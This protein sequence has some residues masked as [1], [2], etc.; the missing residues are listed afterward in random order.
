M[1]KLVTKFKYYKPG[2]SVSMGGYLKYIATREGVEKYVNSKQFAPPTVKQK[3]L[4]EKML[5]EYPDSRTM[6]EYEDYLAK[7]SRK[8]AT[9]FLARAIEDNIASL[10]NSKTYAD[11]IA[12]RPGTERFGTH[13]LFTDDE[14]E[15][16]LSKV[17]GELNAHAGN[18]WTMIVS[19]RR[20]DAVRLG[21]DNASAWRD[22]VRANTKELADAFKIPLTKLRW[23]AAFHN[24]AHH[25]HIHVMVYS[26]TK[27]IGY[28]TKQGVS[29]MRAALAKSIFADDLQNV[30]AEQ[31]VVRN[32][33]KSNVKEILV[34]IMRIANLDNFANGEIEKKLLYLAERLR[35]TKGKKVY[36]YLKPDVKEIIDSIVDI[37][38]K[39]DTINALYDLWYEKKFSALGM[40]ASQMPPR[41]PLADNKEF[42]SIKNDIIREALLLNGE[43]IENEN[44]NVN[45]KV[46]VSVT[47]LFKN[48]CSVFSNKLDD[49]N[50][51][52]KIYVSS[53]RRLRR[54]E[55][56]KKNA[57]LIYD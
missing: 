44:R 46:A 25:P 32:E 8:T 23:Y 31:T 37:L 45:A 1:S 22:I 5:V 12:T 42:K 14:K 51:K 3:E 7:P 40:Y 55:E 17:S 54:E 28:L 9:E 30:Y 29:N 48:L 2:A 57:E 4:I 10:M 24:S 52:G 47:R 41:I 16:V 20:E 36:G 34:E 56:A 26:D 38:A 49:R 6:L 18:V 35:R 13:G 21:F 15:I 27:D 53:D 33:L 11:Y 43:H 50:N 39:D 19:L